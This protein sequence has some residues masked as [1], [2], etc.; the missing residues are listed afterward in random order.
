MAHAI[1]LC[2]QVLLVEL[3]NADH[4]RHAVDHLDA[5]LAKLAELLRVVG[6]GAHLRDTEV[7]Q[8][9]DHSAIIPAVGGK[10]EGRVGVERVE[11]APA[12]GTPSAC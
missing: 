9:A 7:F 12:G 3:P 2:F 8:D 11:A 4:E 5:T 10:T 6:D 1:A